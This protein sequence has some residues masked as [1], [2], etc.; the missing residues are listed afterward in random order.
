MTGAELGSLTAADEV[1]PS[2]PREHPVWQRD[3]CSISART[4]A[5]LASLR[6]VV[7]R[8]LTFWD[9]AIRSIPV[10]GRRLDVD[11]SGCYRLC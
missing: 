3:C 5:V 6:P 10:R 7:V 9:H 1:T 2:L 8:V 11:P 4:R